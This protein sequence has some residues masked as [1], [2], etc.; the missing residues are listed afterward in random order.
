M[1]IPNGV[2]ELWFSISLFFVC[3][4]LNLVHCDEVFIWSFY[5]NCALD[6]CILNYSIST[7]IN[8]SNSKKAEINTSLF[9]IGKAPVWLVVYD[10]YKYLSGLRMVL[11]S[12]GATHVAVEN[13][14]MWQQ[15]S[16]GWGHIY[17][18]PGWGVRWRGSISFVNVILPIQLMLI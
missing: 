2:W 4:H 5:E 9:V 6:L 1:H 13:S 12:H 15:K 17:D 8:A 3:D 14:R 11:N 7:Q 18:I 16:A 10:I